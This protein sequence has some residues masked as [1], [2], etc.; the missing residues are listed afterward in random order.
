MYKQIAIPLAIFLQS[1]CNKPSSFS[2]FDECFDVKA[3]QYIDD[4][5][6]RALVF[7]TVKYPPPPPLLS[8]YSP[9]V[10]Q[11]SPR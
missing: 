4:G 7:C 1:G 11:R 10:K 9:H 8:R 6:D 3:A 2:N 5:A